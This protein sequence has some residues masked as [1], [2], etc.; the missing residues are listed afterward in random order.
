MEALDRLISEENRPETAE[1]LENIRQKVR[2]MQMREAEGLLLALTEPF[3]C[4][5]VG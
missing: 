1:A 2:N 5:S 4:E 3:G